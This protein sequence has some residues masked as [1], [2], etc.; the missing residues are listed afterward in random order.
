MDLAALGADGA[1]LWSTADNQ[2]DP[3]SEPYLSD[4]RRLKTVMALRGVDSSE[5]FERHASRWDA[6]V[7]TCLAT[8]S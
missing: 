4:Q 2:I 6:I 1:A 5:F 7:K 8:G 3:S